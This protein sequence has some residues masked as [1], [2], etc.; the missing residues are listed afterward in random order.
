MGQTRSKELVKISIRCKAWQRNLISQ[1]ADRLGCTRSDFVLE[2]AC[3]RA[4][5]VLL[6]QT[7]FALD[8]KGFAA[9][10]A[11]LDQPLAPNDC[12]RRTLKARS[13]W[14]TTAA[15]ASVASDGERMK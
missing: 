2:S 1:A 13:P 4:E 5:E 11:M 7:F 3:R 8:A 6:D 12:L 15:D 10:Q 14:G 9:L